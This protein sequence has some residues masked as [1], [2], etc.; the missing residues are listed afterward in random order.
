M[1]LPN[2]TLPNMPVPSVSLPSL[3]AVH[4]HPDD[5]SLFSGGVL[6]QHAAAGSRTAVVTTMWW[7]GATGSP[8]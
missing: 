3:L 7:K 2:M 4:A 6:S 5:E 8:P 1:S